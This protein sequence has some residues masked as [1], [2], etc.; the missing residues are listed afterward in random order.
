MAEGLPENES[1]VPAKKR[2]IGKQLDAAGWGLFFIWV[3]VALLLDLSWGVGL[4]GVA[5][6]TLLGQAARKY[7]GLSLEWFWL[8]VGLLF[9]LGGLWELYQV[10]IDLVPILLIIAGAALLISIFR[11]RQSSAE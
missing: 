4:L 3:G 6:I 11:R 10:E 9:L 1:T 8:V 2:G 7:Y 5:I